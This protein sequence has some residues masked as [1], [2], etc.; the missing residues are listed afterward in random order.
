MEKRRLP[1][2]WSVNK[3]GWI[4]SM[5][6]SEYFSRPIVKRRRFPSTFLLFWIMLLVTHQMFLITVKILRSPLNI[7][8]LLKL[9]DQGVTENFKAHCGAVWE[10]LQT[11]QAI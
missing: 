8:S 2:V 7:I 5:I 1:V 10:L 9:M 4:T 11:Y 3:K 6:F